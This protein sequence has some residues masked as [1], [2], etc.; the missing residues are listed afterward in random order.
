MVCQIARKPRRAARY[1][2]GGAGPAESET[3]C[4][5]S[6]MKFLCMQPVPLHT[7]SREVS[8]EAD[9]FLEQVRERLPKFGLELHPD[10]TRLMEFGRVAAARRNTRGEGKPETFNF[11]GFAHI[12]GTNHRTGNLAVHRQTMGKRMAAKL[13]DIKAKLR[14]RMHRRVSGTARWL[15]QVCGAT[16]TTRRFRATCREWRPSGG[17]C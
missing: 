15:Q 9:G 7:G 13:R 14:T 3:P 5:F 10:K 11:L 2:E 4:R 1:R 6:R 12:C 17:R 8:H 16:S